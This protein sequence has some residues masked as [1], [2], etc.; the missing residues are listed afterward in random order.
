MQRPPPR[1]TNAHISILS[2][3]SGIV[4]FEHIRHGSHRRLGNRRT[5]FK[6]KGISL[7]GFGDL[8]RM[9]THCVCRP[10]SVPRIALIAGFCVHSFPFFFLSATR[11]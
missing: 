7:I 1:L 4:I 11:R 10:I 6:D 9:V 2:R 8:I 5:A 3:S